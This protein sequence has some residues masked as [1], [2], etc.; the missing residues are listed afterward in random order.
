MKEKITTQYFEFNNIK[1]KHNIN[2]KNKHNITKKIHNNSNNHTSQSIQPIP[3]SRQPI[4]QVGRPSSQSRQPIPQSRQPIPQ[5][6]KPSSQVG[7]PSSQ[8]G[9]PSPQVGKPS[10][11]VEKPSPQVGKPSSQVGKPSSQVGRKGK[12][13]YNYLK[14]LTRKSMLLNKNV[15][16]IYRTFVINSSNF[17]SYSVY[18]YVNI[19]SSKEK[20]NQYGISHVLEHMIFK[21]TSKFK[22]AID[23][24]TYLE[25]VNITFN[26]Y[27]TSNKT[28]YMFT[29]SSTKHELLKRI[30]V[31][32][33]EM[34][35]NMK[36]RDKD[37]EIEKNII[38]QEYYNGLDSVEDYL[39]DIFNMIYY[40]E[41][42]F[43]IPTIGYIKD[44]ENMTKENIFDFYRKYY[45]SRNI[46]CF[47]FGNVPK[48]SYCIK[49]YKSYFIQKTKN[50]KLYLEVI[51]N[52]KKNNKKNSKTQNSKT[53]N[54]KT[55]NS[56]TQN[57][58][59]N[60][61]NIELKIEELK[62]E[63][64][65]FPFYYKNDLYTNLNLLFNND[66]N[67]KLMTILNNNIKKYI[68]TLKYK[69]YITKFNNNNSLLNKG[70]IKPICNYKLHIN[71]DN[72]NQSYIKFI[73]LNKGYIDNDY[74]YIKLF[75][76]ILGN[77]KLFTNILFNILREKYGL[78][79]SINVDN[80]FTFEDGY[81]SISINVNKKN[82]KFTLQIME[83]LFNDIKIDCHNYLYKNNKCKILSMD[84]YNKIIAFTKNDITTILDDINNIE[85]FY[86]DT[87]IYEYKMFSIN[88]YI[89]KLNSINYNLFIKFVYQYIN[90]YNIF[91][92]N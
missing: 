2:H 79:Y 88:S 40:G 82:E 75:A 27:T 52:N 61:N 13:K 67:N 24:A 92:F 56:K 69:L 70:N 81:T 55:Q 7:R 3:Q 46:T 45:T 30:F 54:G 16:D 63:K 28:C 19:G 4:P 43:Y 25:D 18:F 65:T 41:H 12:G 86:V 59:L 38:K 71:I 68:P 36:I 10:S 26:A 62:N 37:L 22:T 8:V 6:G 60:K 32:A 78:T 89:N 73:F 23:M 14:N 48:L 47:I 11:Q 53:Q 77:K 66:N 42:P 87:I 5:V 9:K 35:F 34:L 21:Q 33:N 15:E 74:M 50:K 91:I 44:I 58:K 51:K 83:K 80:N 64:I 1:N 49:Y 39:G 72:I 20:V 84:K 76:N 85:E 29:T 90:E 17:S 31:V 57:G